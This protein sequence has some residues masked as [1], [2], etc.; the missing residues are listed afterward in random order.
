MRTQYEIMID[1]IACALEN[2]DYNIQLY[3]DFD[4][5][6]VVPLIEDCDSYPEEGHKVIRIEPL[7]SRIGYQIMED[8]A[9][10]VTDQTDREK[11]YVALNQRHPFSSFNDMLHYTAQREKWF[12]FKRQRMTGIVKDWMEENDIVYK[13]ERFICN[14]N[15]A[16]EF[17]QDDEEEEEI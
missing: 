12:E 16:F 15:L 14:G 4:E 3:F 6:R 13:D 5:Q 17:Y 2:H 1:E 8:F 10:S 9:D 11:L 7:S